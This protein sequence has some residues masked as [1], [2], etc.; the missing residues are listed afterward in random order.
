[1]KVPA[2]PRIFFRTFYALLG[3]QDTIQIEQSRDSFQRSRA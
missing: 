2:D 3:A 1:L